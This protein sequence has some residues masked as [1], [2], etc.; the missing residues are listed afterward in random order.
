MKKKIKTCIVYNCLNSSDQGI[1]IGDLCGPCHEF[2]SKNIGLYS[3]AA[4]N[5]LNF[6]FERITQIFIPLIKNRL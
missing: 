3:Q 5:A 6:T 1:F 2:I 4:K